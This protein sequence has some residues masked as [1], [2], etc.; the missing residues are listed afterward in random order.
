[1]AWREAAQSRAEGKLKGTRKE[2][3]PVQWIVLPASMLGLTESPVCAEVCQCHKAG[4]QCNSVTAP[5]VGK[6]SGKKGKKPKR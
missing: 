1:M 4:F 5:A 3:R 6:D 2:G